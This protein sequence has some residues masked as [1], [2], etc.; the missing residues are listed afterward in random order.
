MHALFLSLFFKN[1]FYQK[2]QIVNICAKTKVIITFLPG[3][4]NSALDLER[5]KTQI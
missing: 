2:L 1:K 4:I 5:V 3:N